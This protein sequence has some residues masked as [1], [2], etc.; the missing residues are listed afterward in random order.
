MYAWALHCILYAAFGVL[1]LA[2]CRTVSTDPA[3]AT[4]LGPARARLVDELRHEGIYDPRVL[5]AI[6]RVPR[7]EFVRP[8]DRA[9]SYADEALPIAGGQTISQPYIVGFMTQLL[10]LQG[11]ERVLEIGTGSGYQ[12]AVLSG[13]ARTVYSIEID[14]A[15]AGTAR[16][17]LAR[18]GYN[19]VQV[20]TGD[21]SYG[22]EEAAPFDAI[23]VTAAAPRI[24]EPLIAQLK[25]EGRLV[26]PLG[27]EDQQRLI[28]A[29]LQ[30][31]KVR[32]ERFAD[33]LFVPMMGAVR[34]PAQ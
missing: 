30:G 6:S 2:A 7:E 11:D 28:R 1:C 12:A 27:D 10:E 21:G 29:R 23:V 16:D 3:A 8:Q 34:T 13:L 18:L 14:A 26:M 4:D 33:V 19:N 31:G 17:R 32:V 5:N 25:P 24:P 15:L 20:R 9:R 22:W